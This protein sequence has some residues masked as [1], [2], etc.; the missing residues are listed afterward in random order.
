MQSVPFVDSVVSATR[1]V[2]SFLL[3][4]DRRSGAYQMGTAF[5]KE[6]NQRP[7][8]DHRPDG[9]QQEPPEEWKNL[10]A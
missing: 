6:G 3:V 9:Q 2:Q 5:S 10:Q 4:P 8:S 1:T 7:R